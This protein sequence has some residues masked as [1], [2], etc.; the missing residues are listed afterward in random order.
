M[1]IRDRPTL[2]LQGDADKVVPPA[3]AL[4][5]VE[6]IRA[7]GGTVEHRSYA[8]EGH[9]W[10]AETTFLDAYERT[11]RFLARHVVGRDA[12]GEE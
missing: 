1:C 4:A 2:V 10:A 12:S 6:A 3:Q 11:E 5:L 7:S 9:G 8:G